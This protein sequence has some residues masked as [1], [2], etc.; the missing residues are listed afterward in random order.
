MKLWEARKVLVYD[1]GLRLEPYKDSKGL[2][3]IGIGRLIGARLEDLK[4]TRD[5]AY[6]LLEC[7]IES[8]WKEAEALFG[9]EFLEALEPAR[10]VAILSLVY[11][12]GA[13]KLKTQ[14]VQT[15]PAIRKQD[16]KEVSRLLSLSKWARDVDPKQRPG[17][18]RDDRITYMFRTGEFPREYGIDQ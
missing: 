10:Q 14:F 18:G 3:T 13:H 12:L 8:H 4:L 1:E 9:K 6:A 17:L 15:V 16:W 5:E 11:N 7:S 2:W